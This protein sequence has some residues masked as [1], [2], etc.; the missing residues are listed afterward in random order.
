MC[1]IKHFALCLA[2]YLNDLENDKLS[3]SLR[4]RILTEK[5]PFYGCA[6]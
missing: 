4:K 2:I 5:D 1:V 6:D 3:V